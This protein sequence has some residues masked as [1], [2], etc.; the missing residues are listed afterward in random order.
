MNYLHTLYINSKGRNNFIFKNILLKKNNNDKIDISQ[1][2]NI[3]IINN[4]QNSDDERNNTDKI[5]IL[6]NF[7]ETILN[8]TQTNIRSK[9]LEK[10]YVT[11]NLKNFSYIDENKLN[12]LLN[13]IRNIREGF[14]L[15]L[16]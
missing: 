13:Y 10:I 2:K 9:S 5:N 15:F 16:L 11:I 1:E 8:K 3:N 14:Y 4:F 12:Y 7:S 6:D